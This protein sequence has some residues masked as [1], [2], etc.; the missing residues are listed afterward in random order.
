[1][2]KYLSY[3]RRVKSSSKLRAEGYSMNILQ[4]LLF[5]LSLSLSAVP[6]QAMDGTNKSFVDFLRLREQCNGGHSIITL[7]RNLKPYENAYCYAL[8]NAAPGIF[9]GEEGI[10]EDEFEDL[11][12]VLCDQRPAVQEAC[13]ELAGALAERMRKIC[14][15]SEQWR[16]YYNADT[17]IDS[18]FHSIIQ[19]MVSSQRFPGSGNRFNVDTLSLQCY[20]LLAIHSQANSYFPCD[21]WNVAPD[22]LRVGGATARKIMQTVVCNSLIAVVTDSNST[23]M[24]QVYWQHYLN[25][26]DNALKL[27]CTIVH[28][29]K[30]PE[31]CRESYA[32]ACKIINLWLAAYTSDTMLCSENLLNVLNVLVYKNYEPAYSLACKAMERFKN[33]DCN[34]TYTGGSKRLSCR[35][36]PILATLMKNL[37]ESNFQPE[38]V[39]IALEQFKA[40]HCY[41]GHDYRASI[42]YGKGWVIPHCDKCAMLKKLQYA[43][44]ARIK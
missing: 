43:C 11:V 22:V 21:F 32:A 30:N 3:V 12:E 4:K 16:P 2:D 14:S 1:M 10:D 13:R 23:T 27:L 29:A 17:T 19:Y 25:A 33:G 31:E 41:D 8:R 24:D 15:Q 6:M 42:D 18:F 36:E 34:N 28:T 35:T 9:I 26:I 20:L 40:C 44:K 38:L 39:L 37:V 7:L 5:A